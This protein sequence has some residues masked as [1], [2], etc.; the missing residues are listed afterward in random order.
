MRSPAVDVVGVAAVA[1]I[2]PG[3]GD[4]PDRTLAE[5]RRT[6][7]GPGCDGCC[8]AVWPKLPAGTVGLEWARKKL[9]MGSLEEL[10]MAPVGVFGTGVWTVMG[11]RRDGA[12]G[13]LETMT[14]LKVVSMYTSRVA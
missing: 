9:A 13:A 11:S 12:P 7:S 4:G 6:R 14:W 2:I 3:D 8:E 10:L 1:G 5:S